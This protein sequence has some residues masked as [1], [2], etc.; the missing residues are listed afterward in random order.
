VL[1]DDD[2]VRATVTAMWL[3][4]MGW[5]ELAVLVDGL[6]GA[7]ETGLAPPPV[8]GLD[9]VAVRASTA[10][11]VEAL[12]RTQAVRII[13]V[14][15]SED[16]VS[17]HIP[18]AIWCSRVALDAMLRRDMHQGPTVLTSEDGVLAQLAAGDLDGA[19]SNE[20]S[21]LAGGAGA[22][23]SLDLFET[24]VA[25]LVNAAAPARFAF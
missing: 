8:L 25:P 21:T 16:Y 23:L 22:R 2:T 13:D 7:L 18:G 1:V 6:G 24:V 15:A 19:W 10:R 3:A 9:R 11:E 14:G 4:Q 20:I 5:G 17:R 12:Q